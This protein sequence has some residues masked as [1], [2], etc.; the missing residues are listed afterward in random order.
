M[1]SMRVTPCQPGIAPDAGA[2]LR[3]GACMGVPIDMIEP[4]GFVLGEAPRQT[5]LLPRGLR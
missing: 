3:L 5:R 4:C 1:T 2:V